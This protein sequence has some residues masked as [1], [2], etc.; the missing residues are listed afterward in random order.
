M[1]P[2]SPS[3]RACARAHPADVEPLLDRSERE[4]ALDSLCGACSLS[5]NRVHFAGTCAR[6][7]IG[8]LRHSRRLFAET[9]ATAAV[10]FAALLPFML[11]LYI[12]GVEISQG[13]SAD[14]KVTM[15]SRTVADLASRST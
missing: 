1:R 8:I 2:S 11:L 7:V 10:E 12:G 6:A 9:R 13:V 3:P 15:T 5:A 14:R 4:C